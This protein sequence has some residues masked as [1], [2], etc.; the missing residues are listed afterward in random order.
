MKEESTEALSR[1]TRSALDLDP[2]SMEARLNRALV[3]VG[4]SRVAE[5]YALLCILGD[6]VFASEIERSRF[7]AAQFEVQMARHDWGRAWREWEKV[8]LEGLPG[9]LV[10]RLRRLVR[11]LEIR[12]GKG[13]G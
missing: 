1:L 2:S 8:R 7:H 10:E 12:E 6:E 4:E 11:E 5:A 9:P 3:L 13:R